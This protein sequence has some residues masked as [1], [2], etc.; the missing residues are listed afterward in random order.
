MNGGTISGNIIKNGTPDQSEIYG[1][2][3]SVSDGCTFI[4]KGG[5]ISGNAI[6]LHKYSIQ[7]LEAMALAAAIAGG[8]AGKVNKKIAKNASQAALNNASTARID[9][10]SGRGA[11]VYVGPNGTF[12]KT[13]GT[14]TGYSNNPANGNVIKSDDSKVMN[15]YMNGHGHAIFFDG[16]EKK[17][18]D[19]TVGPEVTLSFKNGIFSEGRSEPKEATAEQEE[20]TAP[21]DV[22]AEAQPQD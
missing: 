16:K 9:T 14:I 11:G 10:V 4:M 15:S 7:E 12:T 2:G 5:T 20:A 3:V 18:I 17:A 1:A 8:I 19:I 22:S 6:E 21:S 13:G